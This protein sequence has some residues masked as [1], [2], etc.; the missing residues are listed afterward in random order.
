[1][2]AAKLSIENAA[3]FIGSPEQVADRIESLLRQTLPS[4][5]I[6]PCRS[7]SSMA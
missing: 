3:I 2:G 7:T 6:L 1:L 5:N 4:A